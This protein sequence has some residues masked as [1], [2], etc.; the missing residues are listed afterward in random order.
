V[1][2]AKDHSILELAHQSPLTLL[3]YNREGKPFEHYV[4]K[5]IFF[6]LERAMKNINSGCYN[7]E[8]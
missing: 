5:I 7:I 1:D 8:C 3:L 6:F 4:P 2:Q